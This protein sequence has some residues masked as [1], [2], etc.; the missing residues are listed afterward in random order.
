MLAAALASLLALMAP[1]QPTSADEPEPVSGFA[2]L[3]GFG[4]LVLAHAEASL[5]RDALP[6]GTGV[7]LEPGLFVTI[8]LERV[9]AFDREVLALRSGAVP[10][11]TAARECAGLCSTAL[12]DA[13]RAFWLSLAIEST[14]RAT[15]IPA[16]LAVVA[17]KRVPARTMLQV[18]YAAAIAR[19]V[20]PPDLALVVT[21]GGRGLQAQ[22]FHLLA[23]AGLDIDQGAAALGLRL[24][25][26]RDRYELDAVDERY[27]QNERLTDLRRL[28]AALAGVK[29]RYPNKTAIVLEPDAS[30]T[31]ADLVAVIAAVRAEFP[32]IVLAAGQPID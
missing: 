6:S 25:F 17:D 18:V 21:A 7:P 8:G 22:P 2:R 10:E 23:P 26:G 12:F 27:V 5:G 4:A 9:W 30:V 15:E 19:P 11:G 20:R 16:R 1:A 13:M 32:R 3:P 31:V 24:R 29:K 28:A 14:Q